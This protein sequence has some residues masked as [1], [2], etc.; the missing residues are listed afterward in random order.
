L[1][2]AYDRW[3]DQPGIF[4]SVCD[5]NET[6]HGTLFQLVH[7]LSL[8]T[9]PIQTSTNRERDVQ[10][11]LP[12]IGF[13]TRESLSILRK[14]PQGSRSHQRRDL[15]RL[16]LRQRSSHAGG[17]C[18]RPDSCETSFKGANSASIALIVGFCLADNI[19]Q[20]ARDTSQ[21]SL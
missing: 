16:P 3:Q 21:F 1:R 2:Q 12:S 8:H 15:F 14:R 17:Y 13:S 6:H 10:P 20:R 19:Q 5:A 4:R 9:S 18:R 11:E 7:R